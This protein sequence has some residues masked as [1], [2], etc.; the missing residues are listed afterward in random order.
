MADEEMVRVRQFFSSNFLRIVC[1]RSADNLFMRL[2]LTLVEA[3]C[4]FQ[5]TIQTLDDRVLVL[6]SLAGEVYKNG[7][8]K[9]VLNEGMPHYRNPFEKG[10]LIIHFAVVFPAKLPVEVIPKLESLLP[11]RYV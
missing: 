7:D 6:N 11:P 4:G 10:R 1:R 2:E 5:R 9:C 3:L 8:T